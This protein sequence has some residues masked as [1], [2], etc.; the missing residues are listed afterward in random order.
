MKILQT[1][2][3]NAFIEKQKANKLEHIQ[4]RFLKLILS[5]KFLVSLTIKNDFCGQIREQFVINIEKIMSC[6]RD[7][8][9]RTDTNVHYCQ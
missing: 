1:H 2:C 7:T 4:V 9:S 3:M 6:R 8:I 5:N